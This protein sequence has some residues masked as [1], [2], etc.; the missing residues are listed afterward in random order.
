ML[1]VDSVIESRDMSLSGDFYIIL[2]TVRIADSDGVF[3][4]DLIVPP[5]CGATIL[6]RPDSAFCGILSTISIRYK[7]SNA[8]F[9]FQDI[10]FFDL[11]EDEY[12][13]LVKC[14]VVNMSNK[15]FRLSTEENYLYQWFQS[16][17]YL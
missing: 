15:T 7:L 11:R 6:V 17:Q 4:S 8:G 14:F 1:S 12:P 16:A 10:R 5:C 2:E 9:I 3:H 13:D